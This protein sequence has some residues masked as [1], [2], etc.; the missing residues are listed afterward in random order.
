VFGAR[1]AKKEDLVD[2]QEGKMKRILILGGGFAGLIAAEQL[3]KSLSGEHQITLV[4]TSRKFTFYPALVRLAF[5]EC[6]PDDIQFDL[7][8]KLRALDVRYIEG[9]VVDIKANLKLVRVIGKDFNGEI[10]YDYLVIAMGRR[11]ATEKVHGFFEYAH[12]LLGVHAAQEFGEAI[13]T[14]EQGNIVVGLAPQALLPVPACE[15]AFALAR[16][17]KNEIEV[18]RIS[19][20]IV[21]PETIA[22]AFGGAQ[23]RHQLEKAFEKHRIEIVTDFKVKEV[24]EKEIISEQNK[25]IPYDLLM[26]LPPFRGRSLINKLGVT[27]DFS[28]I[29]AD[30]YMRV[31]HFE[32]VYAVGDIVDFSGPKLAHMAVRQARVAAINIVSE[33]RGKQPK[34]VYYHEIATII[35]EGGADSIYLHYGVWDETPYKLKQG[36]FWGW[37]KDI[38]DRAWM[39]FHS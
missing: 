26:L 31:P 5:G 29:I 33:I 23:L 20:T 9:E 19:L 12:H 2:K 36:S 39:S 3:S 1:R 13:R 27:D 16:R 37:V 21:F 8:E 14:F 18:R 11:L 6:E 15:A 25:K 35:D 7:V 22:A 34:E 4:S 32:G 17:F 10:S 38:H 28:F 24:S 30:E